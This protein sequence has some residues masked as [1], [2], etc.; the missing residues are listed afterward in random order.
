MGQDAD[1]LKR[2]IERTRDD[3]GGTLDAIGDR[4]SPSRIMERRKNRMRNTVESMRTRVMGTMHDGTHSVH[5]TTGQAVH[6]MSDTMGSAVDSVKHAP[7]AARHRTEGAPMVA[8]ALAFGVGFLA[9]AAFPPSR[10][11]QQMAPQLLD[12]VEP[13]KDE[14]TSAGTE[15]AQHLQEPAKQ[16]AAEIGERVKEGAQEVS[17]AAGHEARTP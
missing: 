8:G 2:D 9:A 1:E 14:L 6:K 3:L 17:T 13:L 12:K 7:D 5:E 16:H 11:E 15:I 4:V 10:R